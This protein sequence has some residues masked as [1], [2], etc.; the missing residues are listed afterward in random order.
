[1]NDAIWLCAILI[2]LFVLFAVAAEKCKMRRI[3][4]AP[5]ELIRGA[6]AV[7]E[8]G[9]IHR[10]TP[11]RREEFKKLA[12]NFNEMVAKIFVAKERLEASKNKLLDACANLYRDLVKP[13]RA[14]TLFPF[15]VEAVPNGLLMTNENGVIITANSQIE[16][17]FYYTKK[18]L[19]GQPVELLIPERFRRQHLA[20]R[21]VFSKAPKLGP[22][23]GGR[24]FLA[25]R[26]DGSEFP[27]DIRLRPIKMTTGTHVL[28]SILDISERKASEEEVWQSRERFRAMIEYV[29]DH[30]IIMLDAKGRVLTWNKGAERLRGYRSD[31]ITGKHYSCFYPVE[32]RESGKPE[33][34][35]QTALAEGQC[36]DEGWRLRKDGSKFWASCVIAAVRNGEGKPIGFSNVTHD[37]TRHRQVEEDLRQAKE[38]ADTANKAKSAFLANISHEIRTPMTGILGMTG[39]LADTE[40]SPDQREYCELIRRSG[41]SLL[42]VIN[43]VLD[44]SKVESGKLQL[45]LIDFELRSSV[46][47]VVNLF[48]KEASDKGVE[49]INFV[50]SDVPTKLRGDPGRLRQILSNLISNALKFTEEGE[51]VVR[52]TVLKETTT[53]ANIRFSV[54]D[55]GIGI[56]EEKLDNLF[57]PFT[58]I[59]AS[60][61]RKYGGTGLGLAICRKL[62]ELLGGQIGV[63]SSEGRGSS[64][65]FTLQ[66]LKQ[67]ESVHEPVTP[68]PN[69][70]GLRMLVVEENATNRGV[71]H[72]YLTSLGIKSQ[73]AADGQNALKRLRIAAKKGEPFNLAVLGLRLRSIGGLELAQAIKQDPQIGSVKLLL[74]TSVTQKVDA[75]L[76]QKAGSIPASRNRLAFPA[77][78]NA[79]P[80]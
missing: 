60:I 7:V 3:R 73:S 66:L 62:V 64:F 68:H 2:A 43:E 41:E 21:D 18:D 15:I 35:L 44:F 47:E 6:K 31:E 58:Q 32:D 37:L 9:V 12:E 55:T 11:G 22:M 79:W 70:R 76:A 52:V 23:A 50:R 26:K 46:E 71:L 51:V 36:D 75:N 48:A 49:L 74:L 42:T 29:K 38:E 19:L 4:R 8:G 39:I 30:D 16:K 65:W 1:M 5:G 45:E 40:L 20:H 34:I 69:L 56:P 77:S 53:D 10:L 63:C 33:Q 28:V 54:T 67:R 13:K 25:L 14:E 61:T 72:H 24:E 80:S 57:H 78:L 59:D 27:V 17:L